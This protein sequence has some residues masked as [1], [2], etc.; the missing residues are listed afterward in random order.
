MPTYRMNYATA[1]LATESHYYYDL[2]GQPRQLYFYDIT[3]AMH[4]KDFDDKCFGGNQSDYIR[5]KAGNDYLYGYEGNDYL[6]G[7][8]GSDVISGGDGNDYLIGDS[9]LDP[10]GNDKLY[11]GAGDDVLIG[12]LGQNILDGGEGRDTVDYRWVDAGVTV[13]LEKTSFQYIG[14]G[15][16]DKLVSVED[17]FGT[18]YA[19][20]LIGN[21]RSNLLY[22]QAGD[23]VIYGKEGD[24]LISGGSGNDVVSGGSGNDY[25]MGDQDFYDY[26]NFNYDYNF[27]PAEGGH[28]TIYGDGG[29][30]FLMGG[31]GYDR[32]YGGDGN[33]FLVGFYT[34]GYAN[35]SFDVYFSIPQER[36]ANKLY[37]GNGNDVLLAGSN[38]DRLEGGRGADIFLIDL[39]WDVS[40]A[41][42]IVDFN[43]DENDKIAVFQDRGG[44][45][46]EELIL[47]SLAYQKGSDTY[48]DG[49]GGTRVVLEDVRLDSLT[50]DDFVFLE[51]S[52]ISQNYYDL[53]GSPLSVFYGV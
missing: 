9:E 35:H 21:S 24:D 48:L 44:M 17:I 16:S 33:D 18:P 10:S 27:G 32:L 52:T 42:R 4:G 50:G 12:G 45:S 22:G 51:R 26:N 20:L 53:I 14:A 36:L 11:G 8:D 38:H 39:T 43:S 19:D 29:N 2:F 5:G 46:L 40:A 37:G 31:M 30:D 13:N 6:F 28:D 34:H 7:G 1:P 25:L 3:Y 23:D 41:L 15:V 47:N 49:V